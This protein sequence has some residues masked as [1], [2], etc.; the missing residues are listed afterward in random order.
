MSPPIVATQPE[1]SQ[2]PPTS[3]LP[4]IEKWEE[5]GDEVS[6]SSGDCLEVSAR[7]ADREWLAVKVHA[8]VESDLTSIPI[9]ELFVE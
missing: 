1:H 7:Y 3:L 4:L 8:L 9:D 2:L 5:L 6:R